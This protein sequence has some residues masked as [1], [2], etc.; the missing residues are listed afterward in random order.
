MEVRRCAL[1]MIGREPREGLQQDIRPQGPSGK[2]GGASRT[3]PGPAG[4]RRIALLSPTTSGGNGWTSVSGQY[5][6][7]TRGATYLYSVALKQ[8]GL[9]HNLCRIKA[10]SRRSSLASPRQVDTHEALSRQSPLIRNCRV[11]LCGP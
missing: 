8:G 11:S 9:G 10:Y 6:H 5:L 3:P 2:S 7:T 4:S 1:V